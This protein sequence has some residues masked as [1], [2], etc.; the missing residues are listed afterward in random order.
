MITLHINCKKCGFSGGLS[1]E[2]RGLGLAEFAARIWVV[3]AQSAG[4]PF[5]NIQ[6][7]IR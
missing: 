2:Y 3:G 7:G 5:V 6:K 1:V 4:T